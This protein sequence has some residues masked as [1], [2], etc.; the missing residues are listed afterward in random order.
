MNSDPNAPPINPLPAGVILLAL[1]IVL[2][3]LVLAAGAQGFVGGAEGIGWRLMA[4]EQYAFFGSIFDLMLEAGQWPPEHVMRFV[5]YPFV[6]LGFT[7]M[8]MVLVFLL[9]L[10][11]MV[12]DVFSSWAVIVVFF[13]A[14][15][16]G[17]LVLAL[18]TDD[19]APLAGG[20]PAVYGLIGAFTFILWVQIGAVG[21]QQYQAFTLI[22]VLLFIQLVFGLL[23]GTG[24]DWIAEVAGFCTGF[25]ISPLVSPGGLARTLARLRQ[26]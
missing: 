14:A 21:G 4:L 15:I 2:G 23:F 8:I 5:T 10:G 12:G 22:A 9:A 3:E 26:R 24:K 7:H 25:A 18:V 6:H 13:A 17:A 19:P 16:V 1:P 11:K 20:Y